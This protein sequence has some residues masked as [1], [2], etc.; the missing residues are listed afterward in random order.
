ME[1]KSGILL[2][3]VILIIISFPVTITSAQ[4]TNSQLLDNLQVPSNGSQVTSNIALQNGASYQIVVSGTYF[5][6][7]G[8]LTQNNQQDAMYRTNDKWAT[9]NNSPDGLY[10]DRWSAGSKQWGAYSAD[11]SYQYT[12]IGNGSKVSFWVSSSS[13]SGN[14]GSLTVQILGSPVAPSSITPTPTKPTG[15]AAPTE[16]A[17]QTPSTSATPTGTSPL[18]TPSATLGSTNTPIV[19]ASPNQPSYTSIDGSLTVI[20]ALILSVIV[21]AIVFLLLSKRKKTLN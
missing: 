17:T 20:F 18:V 15:T 1:K 5:T 11:H 10:I 16:S 4:T 2:I 7:A 9:H 21:V 14:S 13:Y 19:T 6:V 8:D 3:T 12:L